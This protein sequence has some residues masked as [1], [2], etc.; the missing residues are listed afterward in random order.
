MKE[1]EINFKNLEIKH[2]IKQMKQ[3]DNIISNMTSKKRKKKSKSRKRRN[4]SLKMGKKRF[5]QKSF[6]EH[7]TTD[8]MLKITTK[9]LNFKN[10]SKSSERKN[11]V[12]YSKSRLHSTSNSKI[13]LLSKRKIDFG[14]SESPNSK[15]F[16]MTSV[17][18]I[19][20]DS[21][22]FSINKRDSS[23]SNISEIKKF[24]NF[25]RKKNLIQKIK[26]NKENNPNFVNV[27]NFRSNDEKLFN[28]LKPQIQKKHL[29][30]RKIDKSK[31]EYSHKDES[32][33]VIGRSVESK[34][35]HNFSVENEKNRSGIEMIGAV[36]KKNLGSGG[37]KLNNRYQNCDDLSSFIDDDDDEEEKKGEFCF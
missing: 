18:R 30:N 21:F 26:E 27:T 31:I 19:T 4:S 1:E 25:S 15:P 24:Q 12:G 37:K 14:E 13:N 35:Y 3:K 7:N 36:F 22:G 17:N 29:E 10:S 34:I 6:H 20:T 16:T 8:F 2:L 28:F 11:R 33:S 32:E 5:K 9:K 23:R